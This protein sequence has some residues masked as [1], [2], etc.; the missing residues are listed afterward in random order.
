MGD[1]E[2]RDRDYFF[3]LKNRQQIKLH[4]Q[5]WTFTALTIPLKVQFG[6]DNSVN[7]QTG[8]NIGSLLGYSLGNTRFTYR[9]KLDNFQRSQELTLGGL[10]NVSSIKFNNELG[11]EVNTGSIALGVGL[12]YTY[13][14]ISVGATYGF[15]WA[16][17]DSS[18]DWNYHDRPWLGF[19][20]GYSLF[21]K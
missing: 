8:I 6:R 18:T 15:D 2:V 1:D 5:Q 17:G 12:L 10:V 14:S 21:D 16:V 20:I 9:S 4:Y 19:A 11:R 7:Y 13:E 3:R